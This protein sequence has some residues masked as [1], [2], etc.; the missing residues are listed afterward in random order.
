[1]VKLLNKLPP[2]EVN[3]VV[4]KAGIR[5]P[6]K[7]I[8]EMLNEL[9]KANSVSNEISESNI[10][11][12]T[13]VYNRCLVYMTCEKKQPMVKAKGLAALK[14]VEEAKKKGLGHGD[15]GVAPPV[16]T[17][18][19]GRGRGCAPSSAKSG[20]GV[21]IKGGNHQKNNPFSTLA[22]A[23]KK[24]AGAVKRK[25]PPH[26]SAG[27]VP[28]KQLSAIPLKKKSP[29]TGAIKKPHRYQP[30]TVAL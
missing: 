14:V 9:P 18:P 28:H 3:I 13:P 10:M 24:S 5:Q 25:L 29:S 6:L 7:T 27:K 1:M 12:D 23:T 2:I 19:S 11:V 21:P 15:G 4:D 30:G 16:T 8:G 20:K 26:E 17:V 22:T